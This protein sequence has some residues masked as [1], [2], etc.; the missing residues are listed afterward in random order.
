[1]AARGE[2]VAR[3]A[4]YSVLGAQ[5]NRCEIEQLSAFDALSTAH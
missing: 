4:Q 3:G 5:K 2:G 1:V